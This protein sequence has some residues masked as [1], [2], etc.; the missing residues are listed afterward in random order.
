MT[1]RTRIEAVQRAQAHCA[2]Q[3]QAIGTAWRGLKDE[4][5][6]VAT[7]QRVLVG[8]V[9]AGFIAGL[10]LPGGSTDAG[11]LV[12]GRLTSLFMDV[13]SSNVRAEFAAGAAL[14]AAEEGVDRDA[15]AGSQS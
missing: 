5:T 14:A 8:G 1:L 6:R 3:R 7:P 15:S 13:L 2:A 11:S 9:V 10:P 12:G 4:T